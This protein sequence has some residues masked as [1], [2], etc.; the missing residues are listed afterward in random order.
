MTMRLRAPAKINLDL[1]VG[2]RRADGYHDI[3]TVFQTL[4]LHD[5]VHVTPRPGSVVVT[6][7]DPS[8]PGGAGNLCAKAI[9]ALWTTT[10][11]A[12]EPMGYA[13]HVEKRVRG[14][15]VAAVARRGRAGGRQPRGGRRH[16]G[17]VPR[18]G[19]GPR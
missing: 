3:S 8:I 14:A 12:G 1:R 7:D 10:G 9:A 15:R 16:R 5:V 11:R 18:V 2:P 4:A 6:T 19:A 17:D 13:V